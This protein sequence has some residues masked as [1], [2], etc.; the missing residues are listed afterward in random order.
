[1]KP[2]GSVTVVGSGPGDAGLLTVRAVELLRQAEVLVYDALVNPELLRLASPAAELI[3]DRRE[4]GEPASPDL[5]ALLMAK[6]HPGR[7]V[8]WLTG[9]DPATLAPKG[10]E[11]ARFAEAGVGLEVVPAVPGPA[12]AVTPLGPGAQTRDRR[13]WL[14]SHPLFGQRVV[15]TRARDQAG[16]LTRRFQDLGAEVLEIPTIKIVPPQQ[17]EDLVD[18]ILGIGSYDWLVFTSA[19]GVAMFFELFFKTF[20]D[21]RAIGGVKIAAVGPGTAAP[22]KAL[23]LRVD[24]MPEEHLGRKVADALARY[25]SLENLKVLL[26][27]AEAANPDLPRALEAL[28]AI[29]DDVACYRTVAETEDPAGAGARLLAAGAEWVVFTSG[30]TVEHFHAR[31]DLPQLLRR[32]PSLRLASIGPE[33]SKALQALALQPAVEAKEHTLEGLVKAIERQVIASR[34]PGA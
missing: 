6:A 23:H 33:T 12:P 29:V 34:K 17:H 27:R 25:E 26:L 22:L 4:P 2:K 11:A 31:F 20:E 13:D 28:G 18:A 30:S 1:M 15:V 5:H 16:P 3:G 8:V 21:V 32:F 24:L 10:R 7:R 14:T 9:G 19:N